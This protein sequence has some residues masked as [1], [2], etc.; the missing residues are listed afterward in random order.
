MCVYVYVYVYENIYTCTFLS[1]FC[2]LCVLSTVV[3][4]NRLLCCIVWC[5]VA[6][7]LNHTDTFS[8]IG[9]DLLCTALICSALL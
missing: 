4:S 9:Y 2:F 8:H 3:L 7:L 1:F 5:C 6:T